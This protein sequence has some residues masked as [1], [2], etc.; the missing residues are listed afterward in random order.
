[1]IRRKETG[2]AMTIAA[3][4]LGPDFVSGRALVTFYAQTAAASWLGVVTAGVV[5]GLFTWQ[6]ALQAQRTGTGD[7]PSLLRR[8]PG[9]AAGRFIGVLYLLLMLGAASMFLQ[10]A[11]HAGALLLPVDSAALLVS[12]FVLA[13][14][15]ILLLS[16]GKQL[17]RLGVCT[18]L[19]LLIFELLLFFVPDPPEVLYYELELRLHGNRAAAVLFAL[20]HTAVGACI[21]AGI[22]VR[23][24][25]GGT[26]PLRMGIYAGMCFAGLLAAGNAVLQMKGDELMALQQPFAALGGGWGSA[27]Y[28]VCAVLMM[29]AAIVGMAGVLHGLPGI[30]KL[31]NAAKNDVKL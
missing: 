2:A 19:C 16:D 7:V 13:L 8:T 15:A 24:T 11:A 26:H 31:R 22:T 10:D 21:S 9:G 3:A 27:G 4:A 18:V 29:A 12:A 5:F 20:M 6:T 1:M 25:G 28:G 23:F 30:A 17:C 14:A